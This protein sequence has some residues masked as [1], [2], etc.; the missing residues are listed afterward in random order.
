MTT[1]QSWPYQGTGIAGCTQWPL[2]F[3]L[4]G[5]VV[6]CFYFQKKLAPLPSTLESRFECLFFSI[7]LF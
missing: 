6:C 7:V 2:A 4:L 1:C 5:I 3:V